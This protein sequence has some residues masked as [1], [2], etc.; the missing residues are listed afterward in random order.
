MR[1]ALLV[2]THNKGH[3]KA[4]E[5]KKKKVILLEMGKRL[6]QAFHMGQTC[7]T[8]NHTKQCST[9]WVI[10]EMQI[11][12]SIIYHFTSISLAKFKELASIK[13][14]RVCGVTNCAGGS[15]NWYN[16]E[17]CHISQ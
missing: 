7:I 17:N 15:K 11:K 13:N 14:W 9:T 16:S 8:N 12:A 10:R 4:L 6:E 3:R 1:E 2:K 5:I